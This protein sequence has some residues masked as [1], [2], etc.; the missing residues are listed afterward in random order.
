MIPMSF[1]CGQDRTQSQV[2]QMQAPTISSLLNL[3]LLP[4][5]FPNCKAAALTAILSKQVPFK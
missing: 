1:L 3:C 5:Y 4:S 2:A